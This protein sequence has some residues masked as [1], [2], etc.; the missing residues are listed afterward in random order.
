MSIDRTLT[1]VVRDFLLSDVPTSNFLKEF[2]LERLDE[3]NKSIAL[4]FRGNNNRATLYYRCH[5]LLSLSAPRQK[6]LFGE[7]NFRHAIFTETY[8]DRMEELIGLG[9]DFGKFKDYLQNAPDASVEKD[10]KTIIVRFPI[11]EVGA[12]RL[13]K[14]LTIYMDLID[15]FVDPAKKVHQFAI[16]KKPKGKGKNLEKDCQQELYSAY[17]LHDELLY[18]DFEY[19]EQ[20][21]RYN[22]NRGRFDLLGL[23]RDEDGYALLLTELKSTSE[24]LSGNSGVDGHRDDYGSY[25]TSIYA[26]TRKQEACNAV[27]LLCDIFKKPYPKELSPETIR[28][29]EGKF[30][31][32]DRVIDFGR[33]YPLPDGFKK[34]YFQDGKEHCY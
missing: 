4:C 6:T 29:I 19:A 32:S 28:R 20:N 7:F 15:D 23:R 3:K 14:I 21:G 26:E 22:G 24:A 34:V 2:I 11:L 16:P 30:V 31:F 18:Y 10:P 17:F 13:K 1:G 8:R 9:V 5:Q 27:R 25:R 33:R 12:D